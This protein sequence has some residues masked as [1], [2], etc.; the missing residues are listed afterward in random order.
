MQNQYRRECLL[1]GLFTL[2]IQHNQVL[3][4]SEHKERELRLSVTED[5]GKEFLNVQL[6]GPFY[7]DVGPVGLM[8]EVV[9]LTQDC[10]LDSVAGVVKVEHN[11]FDGRDT[12]TATFELLMPPGM[13]TK[14]VKI[15]IKSRFVAEPGFVAIFYASRE[16]YRT[17]AFSLS[18]EVNHQA[19]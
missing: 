16:V 15:P 7:D 4:M 5:D 14:T 12:W 9:L 8:L 13:E 2:V 1:S 19:V 3:T 11:C 18:Q 6:G 17:C 10:Q